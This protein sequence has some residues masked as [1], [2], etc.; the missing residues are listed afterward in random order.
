[1]SPKATVLRHQNIK[2]DRTQLIYV[3]N[4]VE[5]ASGE[6]SAQIQDQTS[7]EEIRPQTLEHVCFDEIS[8]P[9]YDKDC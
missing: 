7:W 5:Q 8:L 9:E 4:V 6:D 1:M 2:E 3:L